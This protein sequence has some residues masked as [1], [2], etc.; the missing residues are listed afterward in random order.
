GADAEFAKSALLLKAA[1]AMCFMGGGDTELESTPVL[2]EAG[3]AVFPSPERAI[4]GIAAA[5][6]RAAYLKTRGLSQEV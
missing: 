5:A 4:R 3:L 1:V 6:W 2:N